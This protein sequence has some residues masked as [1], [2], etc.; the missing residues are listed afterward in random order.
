M[1]LRQLRF[2]ASSLAIPGR[3]KARR[4]ADL[5]R[6]I[7]DFVEARAARA[8]MEILGCLAAMVVD[9]GRPRRSRRYA[10]KR[11]SPDECTALEAWLA[12]APSRPVGRIRD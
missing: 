4:K 8:Q 3:S 1:T 7:D 6:L 9:R 2:V 12:R 5:R 10:K 11:P